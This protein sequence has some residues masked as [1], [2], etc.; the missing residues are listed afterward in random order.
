MADF[1]PTYT[2][3][4]R[5]TYRVQTHLHRL[6]LRLARGS[7]EGDGAAASALVATAVATLN[8]SLWTDWEY[9]Q[10]EFCPEDS[11]FFLPVVADWSAV[12]GAVSTAAR[13]PV[14]GAVEAT[15][16][17]TTNGGH[18]SFFALYGT[19]FTPESS[20]VSDDFRLTPT[21]LATV[22]DYRAAWE[23]IDWVGGDNRPGH[24]KL[25]LN[26]HYN[27]KWERRIRGG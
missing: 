8:A 4:V 25:Y 19:V 13:T 22:G 18:K 27:R 15:L 16:P 21:E 9:V 12:V 7:S 24:T 6:G 10:T 3:R 20:G 11:A 23:E 1:A 26:I 17:Y 14:R 5:I 2:A